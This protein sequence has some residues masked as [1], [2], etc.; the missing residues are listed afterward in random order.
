[1][2]NCRIDLKD[3]PRTIPAYMFCL[4]LIEEVV[5]AVL[6]LV[7]RVGLAGLVHLAAALRQLA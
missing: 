2:Q 5:R 7:A 6:G 1:M 3:T 4:D